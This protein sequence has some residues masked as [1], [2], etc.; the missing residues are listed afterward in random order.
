[1]NGQSGP[2]GPCTSRV[3]GFLVQLAGLGLEARETVVVAYNRASN[4]QA[5]VQAD[6]LLGDTIER[7][8]RTDARDAV[9]G[10]LLQLVQDPSSTSSSRDVGSDPDSAFETLHPIA[11]PALAALLALMVSDV[12]PAETVATLYAPFD[13]VIPMPSAT[14]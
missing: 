7:A 11:E 3:R 2:Y 13:A 1:M 10:P 4:T 12:M 14:L 6:R 9:A 5:Y 8:G